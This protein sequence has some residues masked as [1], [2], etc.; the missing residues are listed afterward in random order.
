MVVMVNCG[1]WLVV[2]RQRH[3][4][5]DG[6]C[7]DDDTCGVGR[8]VAGHS[9][10]PTRRVDELLMPARRS[11]TFAQLREMR[12]ASSSVMCSVAGNR[13]WRSASQSA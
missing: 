5:A 13:A 10:E 2:A 4:V 11:H 12:S 6:I 3:I 9:L 1:R 7:R 8:G